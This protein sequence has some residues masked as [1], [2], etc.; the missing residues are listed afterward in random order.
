MPA[1]PDRAP[2]HLTDGWRVYAHATC[3]TCQKAQRWLQAT[4]DAVDLRAIAQDPPSIEV[5]AQVLRLSGLPARKLFNTSGRVYREGGW[6]EKLLTMSED[7]AL[8]ALAADGMLIKRPI[9]LR[10][11]GGEV[12]AAAVGFAEPAWAAARGAGA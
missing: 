5:L 4:G 8:A 10:L 11:R 3:G 2:G 12:V 1:S 6:S 9:G 7:D